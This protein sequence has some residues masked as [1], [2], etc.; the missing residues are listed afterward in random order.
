MEKLEIYYILL[1]LAIS[2]F[3]G[4]A[5]VLLNDP[6]NICSE[7]KGSPQVLS[8]GAIVTLLCDVS[9]T[10]AF[11]NVLTWIISVVNVSESYVLVHSSNGLYVKNSMFSSA[12]TFNGDLANATLTFTATQSL[13]N[14]VVTCRDNLGNSKSCTL[15]I[16]SK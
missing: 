13:N 7:T 12:A 15:L 2:S 16:Y 10:G 3:S 6:N 5:S 9:N 8:A 14:E 1:L 11:F 4:K